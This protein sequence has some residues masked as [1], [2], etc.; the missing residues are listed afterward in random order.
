MKTKKS[1]MKINKP[2]DETNFSK[3]DYFWTGVICIMA[4]SLSAF[5]SSGITRYIYKDSDFKIEKC[6]FL[7]GTLEKAIPVDYGTIVY[8]I[9][10]NR[11]YFIYHKDDSMI[12]KDLKE[13]QKVLLIFHKNNVY[14]R[15]FVNDP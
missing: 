7:T 1:S 15:R 5:I 13:G 2:E 8:K 9:K 11:E 4:L 6:V 3:N 14:I 10:S 12:D